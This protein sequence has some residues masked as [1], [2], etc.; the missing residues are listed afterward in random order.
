MINNEL[1]FAHRNLMNTFVN[2]FKVTEAELNRTE[3][4]QNKRN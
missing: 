4:L 3:M 1:I 2:N